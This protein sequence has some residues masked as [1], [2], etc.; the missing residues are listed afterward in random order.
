MK[1]QRYDPTQDKEPSY[2]TYEVPFKEG[3][4]VLHLLR[5]VYENLDPT[6]AYYASCRLGECAGCLVRVN[7]RPCLACIALVDEEMIANPLV[8]EP[9]AGREVIRDLVV[10]WP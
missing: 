5:Y 10:H 1:V 2:A 8:I 7:G 4:S 3:Y 6:L 9:Q